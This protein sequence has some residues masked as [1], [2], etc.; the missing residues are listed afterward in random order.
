[1][2]NFLKNRWYRISNE[3]GG[4][5]FVGTQTV[6]TDQT[7][8]IQPFGAVFLR[9]TN[10]SDPEQQ[11]QVFPVNSTYVAFRCRSSG[12]DAYMGTTTDFKNSADAPVAGNTKPIMSNATNLGLSM[13][14][15]LGVWEDG[16]YWLEN[17][18]NG[19]SWH[20]NVT[21]GF[22]TMSSNI[23]DSPEQQKFQFRQ[24]DEIN[25]TGYSTIDDSI[26]ATATSSIQETKATSTPQRTSIDDAD[27]AAPSTGNGGLSEGAKIAI[28]VSIG[29]IFLIA[30]V[31]A[32]VWYL[33]RRKKL[34]APILADPPKVDEAKV[35]VVPHSE[36]EAKSPSELD[37]SHFIRAELDGGGPQ[38]RGNPTMFT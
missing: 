5:S 12:P 30:L 1:M 34:A 35:D 26:I 11:W 22:L 18:A 3:D 14:W 6:L 24:Q 31:V 16:N 28:G 38:Y 8:S 36:L 7:T 32:L 19:T 23:T 29:G 33:K 25:D 4:L 2:A 17:A 13:L 10:A 15:K 27:D 37:S 20:L 21:G 9:L